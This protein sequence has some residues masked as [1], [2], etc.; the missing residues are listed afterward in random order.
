MRNAII[1]TGSLRT[2]KRTAKFTKR[3]I[4]EYTTYFEERSLM[5]PCEWNEL[6]FF[7]L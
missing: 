6:E 7:F 4:L 2:I 3:N 1:L 5:M